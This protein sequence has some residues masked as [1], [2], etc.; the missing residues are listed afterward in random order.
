[1]L[2]IF[3][4]GVLIGF[5]GLSGIAGKL[6]QINNTL[7]ICAFIGFLIG[8]LPELWGEAGAH[9]RTVKSYISAAAGF[10]IIVSLLTFMEQYNKMN[11]DAGIAGFVLCGLLWGLSFIVPGL[12]SSTLLI[13]FG[14]YQPMLDGIASFD[15]RVIIPLGI[16]MAACVI[17]LSKGISAIYKHHYNLASHVVIGIVIAT[18]YMI[19]PDWSANVTDSALLFLIYSQ[20]FAQS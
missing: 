15:L 10:I 13:F 12:S 11:I 14:L 3:G 6:M 2:L 16:G 7:V 1:M 8:T 4:I 20:E 9:G 18:V 17:S 5:V 19:L